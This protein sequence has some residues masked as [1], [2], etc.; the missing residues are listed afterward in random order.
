MASKDKELHRE[1]GLR[2]EHETYVPYAEVSK[3]GFYVLS[4]ED[5]MRDSN[6]R[7]MHQDLFRGGVPYPEGCYDA[8]MGSTSREWICKTCSY[9][10]KLC[11]GHYGDYKLNSPVLSPMFMKDIIKWLKVICFNCGKLLV[12]YVK[13]KVPRDKIL[14]EYVRITRTPIKN[15]TCIHCKAVHPHI[16]KEKTDPISISMEA[17]EQKSVTTAAG[18]YKLLARAPLYPHMIASIFDKITNN[19]IEQ[20]G[21]PSICHPRKFILNVMRVPPNTIRPDVKKINAGRSN[22]H[23]FTI[24]LQTIMKINEQIPNLS[25]MT[26]I[27]IDQ[28]LSIQ[29]HNLC[30]A[31]YDLIKGS[32]VTTKRGIVSASKKPLSSIAKRWPRKTGRIRK[33]LMGRRTNHMGRSFITCDPFRKIDEIGVPMRIARNIQQPEIVQEYNYKEMMVYFMNGQKRYPGCTKVKKHT[34]GVQKWVGLIKDD[35]QL[36]IG[37]TIYRDTITGDIVNF[38]RQPSL[39]PSSI[40]SMKCV[41]ME[42]GDTIGFHVSACNLFSADF[43]G[44]AMLLLFPQS[45]RTINEIGTL[46][47]LGQAF[48]SYKDSKPKIGAVIDGVIGLAELTSHKTHLDKF[49]AMSLFNQ[50]NVYHDFSQYKSNNVFTGR[51]A[52]SIYLH[53][54]SNF[55]N[56]TATPTIYN[57][58]HAPFRKYESSDI[59]VEIDRGT[60]K[61]GILD[62][63]T[64]GQ[65]IAGNI[66]HII[67]NQYGPEAALNA[68]FHLQQMAIA[69]MY[70]HGFT[71]GMRDLILKDHAIAAI[72]DVEK[73][74]I[75]ESI[76]ITEQLNAGKIIPPIGKTLDDYYEEQQINALDPGD[77]FWEYILGSIDPDE[78]FLYKLIMTGARGKLPNFNST[79]SAIGQL[80]INGERMKEN[81]AGRSLAYFT[82]YDSSP[83]ARGYIANSY[84]SGITPTEFIFHAMEARFAL[85][86]RALS[87]AITG[88][89]NRMSIKNL[90]SILVDNQRKSLS[91]DI[92]IQF[93]YGADGADP[94]FLEKVKF[95]TM[96]RDLTAESFA[97]EFKARTDMFIFENRK[98]KDIETTLEEEFAQLTADREFY[99]NLFLTMEISMSRN[100]TEALEMP[101][102]PNRIIEDTL[103][104]LELKKYKSAKI[105][106]DPIAAIEK[107]RELCEEMPY[108]LLNRQQWQKRVKLPPHLQYSCKMIQ[109]LIRSYL[110]T[111]TMSHRGITNE[112]LS[113]IIDQIKMVYSRSLVSY[114]KAMGI[115]ASQSI[116]EPMTQ[117][118]LNS[119]H[120]SGAG[121]VRKRGL[122]RIKEILGARPTSKMRSPSMT[123]YLLSEFQKNKIKALEIANHIEMLPFD[124]FISGWQIFY[125]KYGA[126][127]YPAYVDESAFIKEF[128]KYHSHIKVPSDLTNWCIRVVLDKSKLIEK[129]MKIETIYHRLRQSYPNTHIVYSTDNSDVVIMRIYLRNTFAKKG[130]IMLDQVT[131]F[132]EELRTIIVR[133]IDG[134]K[135][136]YVK[137]MKQNVLQKN[138]SVKSD[139]IY[140]IF[141]D[142][143]NLRKIME[144]PHFDHASCSSDSLIEIYD[145]LGIAAARAKI[146]TELKHQV[147]GPSHRHFAIY[148]SVMTYSGIVSSIDR[149]GNAKRNAS[150][151]LRV[152]DASP[153]GVL[154][155]AALNAETDELLGISSNIIIGK[156][157]RFGSTYN[158]FCL[159][160]EFLAQK[161]KS[162]DTLLEEL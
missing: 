52:I 56:L 15:L 124:M 150:V 149:Y 92:I 123:L 61:S 126:P 152:S 49:H 69:F 73:S 32:N 99:I 90:E 82:K 38:N 16:V 26:N 132:I 9:D 74:L 146:I 143:T 6:I 89:H 158:A 78:N 145:V 54:T 33:N 98:K 136:A 129:H 29:I 84:I 79:V 12:P 117:S 85:I 18:K 140:Y 155:E 63:A 106:L 105:H 59:K 75:T 104:N 80:T 76:Q 17:Y 31:V 25:T 72:H 67:N 138:G 55:I 101:I 14:G 86:N 51:D 43:D 60:L 5:N 114:G 10:K 95:P 70:N 41:V 22:S 40:T 91:G 30:L 144:N 156:T 11:P 53:E 97:Q 71:V 141:T 47:S 142:G 13:L 50:V 151:L 2:R 57:P 159:D 42:K 135:A 116:S 39:E 23:D 62:K 20:L 64:V 93:L 94:R 137:E 68:V 45:S 160:E 58:D 81:F 27:V 28:D 153:I 115:I 65:N 34:T 66:F 125:E 147:E 44:D 46:C 162:V 127:E 4:S 77:A 157:P 87:T 36:E 161:I 120:F 8:H 7:V 3:L 102:N 122:F 109:I 131:K 37:D 108:L 100:Y 107:V 121:G 154:E 24:L 118:V 148:A 19:T 112:A 88:T 133:G 113:I 119:H 35:F 48:V 139:T 134:I 83:M 96:K 21:K 1:Q 111:A 103:Y 130:T 110:N 128:E